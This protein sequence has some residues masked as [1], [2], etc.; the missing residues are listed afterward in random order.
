MTVTKQLI[1]REKERRFRWR[2]SMTT[3]LYH[4]QNENARRNLENV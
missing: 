2:P 1:Q 4:K 3:S